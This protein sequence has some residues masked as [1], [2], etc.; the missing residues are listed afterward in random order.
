MRSLK[1]IARAAGLL[2]AVQG[3]LALAASALPVP[4]ASLSGGIGSEEQRT[5]RAAR[6]LYNLRLTFAVAGSG[7]FLAGIPVKIE[8][9]DR[10][11]A[12]SP[13]R[14][15]GPLLYVRLEPGTYRVSATYGGE[16]QAKTVRIGNGATELV[17][18]WSER[19]APAAGA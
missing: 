2:F 1:S 16:T 5:M 19:V 18:Y 7:A 13:Y 10:I 15:S 11:R 14:D 3:S 12:F 8:R 9:L 4:G 6:D 17:F